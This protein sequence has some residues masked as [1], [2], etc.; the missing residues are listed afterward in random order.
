MVLYRIKNDTIYIANNEKYKSEGDLVHP[1]YCDSLGI[2]FNH[3]KKVIYKWSDSN[4]SLRNPLMID[5]YKGTKINDDH[6]LFQYTFTEEDYM[7]IKN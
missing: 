4:Q 7:S 2:I 1:L 6:Y 5:S 3:N